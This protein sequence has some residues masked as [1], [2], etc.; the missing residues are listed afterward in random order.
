VTAAVLANGQGRHDQA[1]ALMRPVI[2]EMHRLGGSHAQQDVLEQLF[3]DSA[4]KAGS[5]NDA[6]MLIE[7][8]T[9]RH[10]VPPNRR[11]GYAMGA[12]LLETHQIA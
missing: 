10:P 9:G 8:A 6:R 11:R 12:Q 2:G 3:L 1:V 4:L 7:R 5:E